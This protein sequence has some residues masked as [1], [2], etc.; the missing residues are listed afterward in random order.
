MDEVKKFFTP[1]FRNRLSNIV[2][3]NHIDS[4]M[5]YNITKS[6][7]N[8]FGEK[9]KKKGIL[10]EFDKDSMDKIVTLGVS[11][12]YGAREIVRVIDREIKPLLIDEVLFGKLKNGGKAKLVVESEKFTIKI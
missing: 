10:F 8:E 11:R 9:L 3:F 5:A 7:L 4:D 6:K 2:V 12:Q 1:E